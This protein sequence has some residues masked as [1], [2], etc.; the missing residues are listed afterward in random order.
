MFRPAS[1]ASDV[2]LLQKKSLK[3]TKSA[4]GKSKAT[5]KSKA[6]GKSKPRAVAAKK[7]AP[8][9]KAAKAAEVVSAFELFFKDAKMAHE[10]RGVVEACRIVST[11]VALL[12]ACSFACM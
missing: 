12:A 4:A 3:K 7:R 10:V 8:R 5:G 2:P 6:A 9:S 1:A 11:A